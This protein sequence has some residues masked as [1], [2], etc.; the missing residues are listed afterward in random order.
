MQ[1]DFLCFREAL[2]T[3]FLNFVALETGLN[4]DGF[5]G[6]SRI[7]YNGVTLVNHVEI[8]AIEALQTMTADLQPAA[9]GPMTAQKQ[10]TQ[11]DAC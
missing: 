1:V 4:I 6:G 11:T 9:S 2:G 5:S 10:P 8:G 3:V 7:H